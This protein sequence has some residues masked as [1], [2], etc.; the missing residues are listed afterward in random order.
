VKTSSK[1]IK[2]LKKKLFGTNH[3]GRSDT[4]LLSATGRTENLELMVQRVP[5]ND[6][7]NTRRGTSITFV[8]DPL[9]SSRDRVFTMGSCFAVEIRK[10]LNERGFDTYPKYGDI[11]FDKSRQLLAKLPE[12]DNI[13]HYNTFVIRQE[14]ELAL[15]GDHYKLEDF[16][17]LG[18]PQTVITK[19]KA[20]RFQ[21]P[22]RKMIFAESEE[23]IVDLSNKV[24]DCIRLA[25]RSADVYVITLGL[26]EVWKNNAN[27]LYLNQAPN[28]GH[29]SFSF[30][31]SNYEQNYGNIA[32]VCS[33]IQKHFPRKRIILTVSPVP[34]TRTF[35]NRDVVVANTESKCTLRAVAA[36]I[37]KEFDNVRYWPS[38]EIALARDLYLEDGRHIRPDGIDLIV[39]QFQKVHVSD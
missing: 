6:W 24:T 2:K 23:T 17:D 29:E 12:R 16:V 38:Y 25:I 22:Y 4:S 32:R 15:E 11:E 20:L 1:I 7:A 30:V 8:K 28:R 31:E 27:G 37:S 3:R 13:N 36:Q 19:G 26:T 21:D 33:L 14:F 34:L 35:T 39:T 18:P 10:A 5:N 9:L